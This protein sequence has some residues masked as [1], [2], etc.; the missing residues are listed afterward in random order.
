MM[1]WDARRVVADLER[2]AVA[3]HAVDLEIATGRTSRGACA[4]PSA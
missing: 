1:R 3:T 4:H 2:G